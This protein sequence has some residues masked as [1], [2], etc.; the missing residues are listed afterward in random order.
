MIVRQA[1]CSFPHTNFDGL[2]MFDLDLF[3]FLTFVFVGWPT[4]RS[5]KGLTMEAYPLH[6]YDSSL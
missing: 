5:F 2:H 3:P 6:T 1:S 4:N